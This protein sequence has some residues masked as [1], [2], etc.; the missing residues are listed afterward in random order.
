[1]LN[2]RDAS[3]I[4]D[5]EFL[6]IR[7]RILDLAAALDRIDRAPERAGHSHFPDPRLAQIEQALDVLKSPDADRTETILRLF[8]LEYSP[9]W[10]E[11]FGLTGPRF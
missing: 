1:M 2:V 4:L 9:E 11:R 3:A 10:R 8:S 6:E 5:R 7:S